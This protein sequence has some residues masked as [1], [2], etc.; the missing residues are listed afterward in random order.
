MGMMTDP[1]NDRAEAV[2]KAL[3]SY[4]ILLKTAGH[5]LSKSAPGTEGHWFAKA[6]TDAIQTLDKETGRT[7]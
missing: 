1:Y 6:I 2:E 7:E 4:R 3:E 5:I